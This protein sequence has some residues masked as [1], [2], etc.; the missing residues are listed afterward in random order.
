MNRTY[1]IKTARGVGRGQACGFAGSAYFSE[2]FSA[3][4][5]ISP[6]EYRKRVK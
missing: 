5:G 6:K 4:V 1:S 2:C 3:R